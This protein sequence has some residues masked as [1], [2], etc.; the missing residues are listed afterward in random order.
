MPL[1]PQSKNGICV[2]PL[3]YSRVRVCAPDVITI[4][5]P[6]YVEPIMPERIG[7]AARRGSQRL[8]VPS[9]VRD[10]DCV[11]AVSSIVAGAVI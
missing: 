9:L 7:L 10:D 5:C 6:S 8:C 11:F 1:F 2:V 3:F 4:A